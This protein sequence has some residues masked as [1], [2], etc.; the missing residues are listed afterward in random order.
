MPQRST[1]RRARALRGTAA[2]AIATTIASTGHT[3]GG[4]E[5]P[6]LWLIVAVTVLASPVAVALVGRRRSLPRT[7]AAVAAAQIA[8]HTVFAAIGPASLSATGSAHVHGPLVLGPAVAGLGHSAAHVSVGMLLAHSLA[9]VVTIALVVSG[10]QLLAVLARGI[11]RVLNRSHP[12]APHLFP[13]VVV[14]SSGPR[15][16]RAPAHLSVL[17]RRGPPAFAR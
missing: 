7:A 13:R 14:L 1:S 17:T 8:L 6:P 2:A 15:V 9:A 4:G 12:P 16:A 3:F 11:R 10:E 5:A